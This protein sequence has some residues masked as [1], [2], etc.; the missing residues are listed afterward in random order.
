[1]LLAGRRRRRAPNAA[2]RRPEKTADVS[3]LVP[4]PAAATISERMHTRFLTQREASDP[5]CPLIQIKP[6]AVPEMD[7]TKMRHDALWFVLQII[8]LAIVGGAAAYIY[9]VTWAPFD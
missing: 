2:Q 3:D 7:A 9:T 5:D 1:M 4:A 6:V 8:G